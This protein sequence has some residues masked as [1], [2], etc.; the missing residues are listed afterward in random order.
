MLPKIN[1]TFKSQVVGNNNARAS[2][3][4]Y[5]VYDT[6]WDQ[7]SQTNGNF[8]KN[9]YFGEIFFS[10]IDLEI[11]D[12]F[13]INSFREPGDSYNSRVDILTLIYSFKM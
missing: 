13:F 7:E 11:C 1:T 5:N 10:Y 2:R 9:I 4:M 8:H 12:F 6:V 3:C